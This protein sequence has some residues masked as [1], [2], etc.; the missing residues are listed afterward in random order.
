MSS[1]KLDPESWR[2]PAKIASRN[3][4]CSYCGKR[5]WSDRGY[6]YGR[7]VPPKKN[8]NV[9][10][11]AICSECGF[12]T[13]FAED[14]SS[15]PGAPP[16]ETVHGIPDDI[17][18]IYEEARRSLGVGAY[19]GTAML[20]RAIVVNIAITEGA[21]D[22][23]PFSKYLEHLAIEGML[24][25]KAK[26]W[27][28]RIRRSD[29]LRDGGKLPHIERQQATDLLTFVEFLLRFNYEFPSRM[30]DTEPGSRRVR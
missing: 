30:P 7:L 29:A 24:P 1:S 25:R 21:P 11:I 20:C 5:T 19:N 22:G 2:D 13:F 16:G 9:S 4:L 27:V 23:W 18:L 15:H 3:W 26:P 6:F 10:C 14:G 17:G 12:P 8:V 28:S